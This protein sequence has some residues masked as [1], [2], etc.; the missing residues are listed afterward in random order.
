MAIYLPA[1]TESLNWPKGP[2]IWSSPKKLYAE[3]SSTANIIA[4]T[5]TGQIYITPAVSPPSTQDLFEIYLP[6][7]QGGSV[8]IKFLVRAS[9]ADS[10][11]PASIY[12]L[13]QGYR[14]LTIGGISDCNHYTT[15]IATLK[16]LPL[17]PVIK[18]QLYRSFPTSVSSSSYFMN[19]EVRANNINTAKFINYGSTYRETPTYGGTLSQ[20]VQLTSSA[21]PPKPRRVVRPG[22]GGV[23][24][25]NY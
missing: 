19:I 9:P 21:P 11:Y 14:E 17:N 10:T 20:E 8:Y 23:V 5:P 3:G 4:S 24:F 25:S 13:V 6:G 18:C 1:Y 12:F 15:I 16:N 7:C 22:G 2:I